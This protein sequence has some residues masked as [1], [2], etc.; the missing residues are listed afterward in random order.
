MFPWLSD[1]GA[2]ALLKTHPQGDV[3]VG[4]NMSDSARTL[5]IRITRARY[6][7]HGTKPDRRRRAA[8][9]RRR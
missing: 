4:V 7:N 5:T 8:K 1:D 6:R 9:Q 2:L 3:L